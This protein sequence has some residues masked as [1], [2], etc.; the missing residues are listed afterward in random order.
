MEFCSSL[1]VE[2][3]Q[4]SLKPLQIFNYFLMQS[5][6]WH[7]AGFEIFSYREHSWKFFWSCALQEPDLQHTLL[8]LQNGN[9]SIEKY[10]WSIFSGDGNIRRFSYFHAFIWFEIVTFRL[11]TL[12]SATVVF[13]NKIMTGTCIFEALFIYFVVKSAKLRNFFHTLL[14]GVLARTVWSIENQ[15]LK[16]L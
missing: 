11:M 7:F 8:Y 14:L 5:G 6:L 10:I 2:L 1:R 15:G 16:K 12:D 9:R 3:S 13:L 4:W